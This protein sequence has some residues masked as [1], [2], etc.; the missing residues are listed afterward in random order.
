[1]PIRA[2][3]AFVATSLLPSA[4]LCD[5]GDPRALRINEVL[6][7]NEGTP[8]VDQDSEYEDLVEIYN[9]LPDQFVLLKNLVLANTVSTDE[10]GKYHPVNGWKF[11]SGSILPKSFITVFCD[12]ETGS[13]TEPHASFKLSAGGEL[14]ALFT[15][16]EE[17][18]DM[19]VFPRT[20]KGISYG[21]SPD[22]A[23]PSPALGTDPSLCFFPTPTFK[24]GSSCNP[25][26]GGCMTA[27]NG[28]CGNVAPEV[29]LKPHKS[30]HENAA[31]ANPAP[32]A[33]V[34]IICEAWDE[35]L[36]S[37]S[38][39]VASVKAVYRVN[40]GDETEEN[41]SLDPEA[42]AALVKSDPLGKPGATI[43]DPNRSI[44]KGQIPGQPKDSIVTFHLKVTDTEGMST[45]DSKVLCG[46]SPPPPDCHV[47][48]RYKVG[49]TNP[50]TL[51]LNEVCPLN[52]SIVRDT[53][54]FKFED[55]IEFV[56]AEETDLSGMCLSTNPFRPLDWA[57]PN[58]GGWVLRWRFPAGSKLAAGEHLLVWCDDDA[59]RTNPVKKEYHANFNLAH[60]GDGIFLFDTEANGFGLID[61]LVYDATA[62]DYAWTRCPDGKR[63]GDFRAVLMGS[64]RAAGACDPK[65][66]RGDP[67][68]STVIDLSDAVS[69]LGYLFLAGEAPPCFDAADADDSGKLDLTDPVSILTYLYM[70]GPEPAAPFPDCGSDTTS[71]AL[72]CVTGQACE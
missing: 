46:G 44:W 54:D 21:R 22:G 24:S 13:S 43:P 10:E 38:S 47:P 29:D 3:L 30:I 33:P 6:A 53:T 41:L 67:D 66:L 5:G 71:D 35:K 8:P 42:T 12:N 48:F 32:G 20:P 16:A 1:M 39:L 52:L 27:V 56:A 72:S 15:N 40:G 64:P 9:P 36:V 61:G 7:S 2:L 4:A 62:A 23:G 49:H 70:G 25:S 63:D 37:G 60:E 18:I 14:I 26:T 55:Y 28:S 19:V 58:T 65:F 34:T 69:I 31:E 59:S 50:G 45:T 68:G 17:L 51:A 57:L 11:T